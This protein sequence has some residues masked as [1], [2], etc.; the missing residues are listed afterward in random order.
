L[1]TG[2]P[3]FAPERGYDIDVIE[4]NHKVEAKFTYLMKKGYLPEMDENN[5]KSKSLLQLI[6]ARDLVIKNIAS[7]IW[8]FD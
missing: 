1:H 8:N 5:V 4:S 7:R 6:V 2:S 3:S